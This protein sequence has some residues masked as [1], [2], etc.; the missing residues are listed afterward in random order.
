EKLAAGPVPDAILM[1]CHMPRLDGWETTR[2]LRAWAAAPEPHRRAVAALPI[3]ALT[4]AALA[5]E[6]QRCRD[7]GMNDFL[8]KPLRLPDLE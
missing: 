5:D 6:R 2:Q 7:A 4:A 8:A 3:I 1:D